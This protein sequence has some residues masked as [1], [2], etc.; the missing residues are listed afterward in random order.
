MGVNILP[1]TSRKTGRRIY[2]NEVLIPAGA[3]GLERA[4][5]YV[6]DSLRR[7]G[8]E[9]AKNKLSATRNVIYNLR[10]VGSY[11]RSHLKEFKRRYEER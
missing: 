8:I 5:W 1:I 11:L 7:T 6:A 3:G 4:T 10:E 9:S 2:P